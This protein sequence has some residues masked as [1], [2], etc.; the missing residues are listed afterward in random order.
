MRLAVEGIQGA[1]PYVNVFWAHNGNASVPSPT[2][3]TTFVT[4]FYNA[5]CNRFKAL[6][7]ANSLITA[8]SIL[9][10]DGSGGLTGSQ[11][12]QNTAC[13]RTGALLPASTACCI[14][15]ATQQRYRGGHPRTYLPTPVD[16]D[17]TDMTTF[18]GAYVTSV[19]TN[20]NAFHADVNA[21]SAGAISSVTLGVV[22]FV[23]SKQWRTPPIFRDFVPG[24]AV[25]D[26]RIDTQRRR[27]GPDR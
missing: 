12:I 5:Y 2:D 11:H 10:W 13:T 25:V 16:G 1:V 22:S 27:L 21:M 7:N 23:H 20:A 9:Y 18:A 26:N 6:I 8:A 24:G 15:W 19:T 14:S 3:L 17:L 4:A